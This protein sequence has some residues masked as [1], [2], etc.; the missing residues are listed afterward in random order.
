MTRKEFLQL[1]IA[2]AGTALAAACGGSA[3]MQA[4]SGNCLANGS[5]SRIAGNHGQVLT[6]TKADIAAGASKT[7]DIRGTADHTHQVTLT[8]ADMAALQQNMQA[9]EISTTDSGH[10]HTIAVLCV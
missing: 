9:Q 3:G 10:S 4:A 1:A 2:A 7:Y 6:V 5:T 8:A